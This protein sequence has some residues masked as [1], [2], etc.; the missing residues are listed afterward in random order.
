LRGHLTHRYL[1]ALGS[2]VRHRLGGPRE[3]LRAA[4]KAL[5]ERGV[6]LVSLSPTIDSAPVGPSRRHYAN[7]VAMID[8]RLE[9]EQL[10]EILQ[11]IESDFGRRRS[12]LAWRARVLDLDIV[13]WSGGCWTSE[14]LTVPHPRFRD[15]PFVLAPAATIAPRWRDPVSG[16]TLRHLAARLTRFNRLPTASPR[17]RALSSVGR[18]TDF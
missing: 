12:G 5:E 4:V 2:N 10:L 7:A 6:H 8:S 14:H 9:P 18:A 3:V 13:L 15:R 16:L 1:V 11:D 17:G